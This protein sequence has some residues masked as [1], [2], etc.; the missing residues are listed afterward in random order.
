MRAPGHVGLA[1]DVA[2]DG[3]LVKERHAVDDLVRRA[4]AEDGLCL[5]RVQDAVVHLPDHETRMIDPSVAEGDCGT[6][7]WSFLD[8]CA[9]A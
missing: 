4:A 9:P 7:G 3:V 6:S 1:E 2:D 8:S 5:L